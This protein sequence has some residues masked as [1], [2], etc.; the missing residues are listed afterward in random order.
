LLVIPTEVGIQ[1][2]ALVDAEKK[3][4]TPRFLPCGE[5]AV[6][7]EFG[8]IIDL[9][10]NRRVHALSRRLAE[11][12]LPG[13][14]SLNPTYR[15]LFV[16]YDPWESSYEQ[17]ILEIEKLLQEPDGPLKD[18]RVM[19]I[20][21]CYGGEYGPDIEEVASAHGLTVEEVITLHS[22]PLYHVYMIGFTPGFAYLG[23][24]DPRLFIPRKTTPRI[25]VPAGSVGI[26]DQQ[27]GI[28]SIES[29]GGWQ[30]IGRTPLKLFDPAR[31]APFLLKAGMSI[32]F[33]PISADEYSHS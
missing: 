5:T 7:V 15:S 19:N 3:S 29:P 24:L 14:L 16:Q 33:I 22:A 9:E 6:S 12:R 13:I 25:R 30:L 2:N 11:A 1:E 8:N 21:V 18:E 17:L 28:Y 4:S 20:P 26:A 27:T 23:G 31:P 32:K 10:V